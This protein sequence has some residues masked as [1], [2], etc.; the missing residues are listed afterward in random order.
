MK[1]VY[2]FKFEKKKNLF[3]SMEFQWGHRIAK[4]SAKCTVMESFGDNTE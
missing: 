1:F 3:H 4:K 2:F